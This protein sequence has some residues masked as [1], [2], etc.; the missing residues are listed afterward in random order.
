VEFRDYLRVLRKRWLVIVVLFLVGSVS[1]L[2]FTFLQTPQYEASTVVFVAVQSSDSAQDL[3]NGSSFAQGEVKS[4]AEAVDTPLVLRPVIAQLGLNETP[5]KLAESVTGNATVDTVNISIVVTDPSASRAAKVANA[6]TSSFRQVVQKITRP[7]GGSSSPVSVSVLQP[8]TVPKQATSPNI[9]LD[10]ALGALAG[11]ALGIA[12]A[13]LI[14]VLDTRVRSERD[15]QAII[16]TPIIGGIAFDPNAARRPLIVQDDPHSVRA[17]SFRSLRTNLQ[18]L[19]V[20]GGPKTYVVT[21]SVPHEGKTTTSANLAIVLADSHASVVIVDA[22]LRRPKLAEYMGLEGAVGLTDV[23]IG[24][25]KLAD[26]IQPWGDQSLYVLP[27]GAIPPNPSELLGSAAMALL[28]TELE[29][30]FDFVLVDLPPLLPVTDAALVSKLTRGALLVVA[31]GRTHRAEFA[32]AVG[33]LE[34]V[35]AHIAGVIMTMLPTKGP[36]A[37]GYGAYGYGKYGYTSTA[38]NPAQI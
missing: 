1:A 3:V 14:E 33:V 26:A 37:Q 7:S 24:R 19:Q 17:E 8:A 20:D 16:A 29:S 21:S 12:I 11:L 10:I 2:A 32:G 35:D 30:Q 36:D 9:K 25:A 18:F 34:N 6:V 28:I 38:V 23:I 13:V 31:A 22:D 27:A 4:Y 15:I 5:A